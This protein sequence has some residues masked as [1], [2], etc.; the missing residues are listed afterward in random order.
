M[1]SRGLAVLF[2]HS[3]MG[4]SDK[5]LDTYKFEKGKNLKEKNEETEGKDEK[6]NSNYLVGS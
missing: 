3:K 1:A 2:P 5:V 4:P 6:L